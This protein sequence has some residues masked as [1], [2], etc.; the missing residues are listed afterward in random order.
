[1][2]VV[3]WGVVS[4]VANVCQISGAGISV[5]SAVCDILGL[6]PPSTKLESIA[7]WLKEAE[8][9]LSAITPEQEEKLRALQG[10]S[11][12]NVE[13]LRAVLTKCKQDHNLIRIDNLQ[14]SAT[15]RF[16]DGGLR[17]R[18]LKALFKMANILLLDTLRTSVLAN[19]GEDALLE[20]E[21][22]VTKEERMKEARS[23]KRSLQNMRRYFAQRTAPEETAQGKY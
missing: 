4:N 7:T 15:R 9:L 11:S 1:M 16:S 18:R 13:G 22:E 3:F 20:Q 23:L 5:G 10:D 6:S 21:T 2:S 17:G 14:S 8:S 19:G 12:N